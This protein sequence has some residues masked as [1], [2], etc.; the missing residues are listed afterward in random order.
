[1]ASTTS[2]K[3]GFAQLQERDEAA[4]QSEALARRSLNALA[5]T[6]NI[7]NALVQN[8]GPVGDHHAMVEA[9]KT[10]LSQAD[11]MSSRLISRLGLESISW[12]RHRLMRMT[13]EAV[14][15]RWIASSKEGQATADISVFLPVWREMAKQDLPT[16]QF[17]EPSE[18]ERV[19]MQISVL[20]AMQPVLQEIISFDMFNDPTRAA[21]HAREQILKAANEAVAELL[22]EN[23]SKRAHGQLLQ[24]LLRNAGG[25]Y[26]SNWRRCAH[27]VFDF[28][29]PLTLEQQ[30]KEVAARPGG[31]PLK[32]VDEG[33]ASTFAKLTDMVAYLA[34]PAAG[35]DSQA[36]NKATTTVENANPH[37]A[38]PSQVPQ[39]AS[40]PDHLLV[41]IDGTEDMNDFPDWDDDVEMP[42]DPAFAITSTMVEP[43]WDAIAAPDSAQTHRVNT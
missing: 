6:S 43:D 22:P 29:A 27:E 17:E 1:M 8:P 2:S 21:M 24:S 14:S 35:L 42:E 11:D 31:W 10:M 40:V 19:M 28:L 13:T 33:F 16:F 3:T 39:S 34:Q 20:D 37:D 26:A 36:D 15:N 32:N 30:E 38:A 12:A 23:T 18:D 25:V 5:V 41:Q 4:R 9:A 7:V